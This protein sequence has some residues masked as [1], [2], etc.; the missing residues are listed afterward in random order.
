MNQ[1]TI[2]TKDIEW[3]SPSKELLPAKEKATVVMAVNDGVY[4]LSSIEEQAKYAQFLIDKKLVSDTFKNASQLIIAIQFCKDLDLPNS[5]LSNFYVVGGKPAIYGD[6]LV[7]LVMASGQVDDKKVEYFDSKGD[8]IT[9]PKKRTKSEDRQEFGCEVSYK[10]KGHTSYV[11]ATYTFDD[12]EDSKT[13]NPTWIKFWKDMLWRRAE[14]RAIKAT[15]PDRLK[16]IEVVE[17]LEDANIKF[18]EKEKA[19]IAT[20]IFSNEGEG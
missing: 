2:T 13:T 14:V 9:R 18:D 10:R 4:T 1:E 20:S 16:G 6:V 15:F 11:S 19:K 17:Y 3:D 5:A 7:G 12:K 8:T